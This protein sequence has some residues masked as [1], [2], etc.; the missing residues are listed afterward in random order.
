MFA[1]NVNVKKEK[2]KKEEKEEEAAPAPMEV[3]PSTVPIRP[4]PFQPA[5]IRQPIVGGSKRESSSSSTSGGQQ[6]GKPPKPVTVAFGGPSKGKNTAGIDFLRDEVGDIEKKKEKKKQL[7][8]E[9]ESLPEGY[10]TVLPFI[11]RDK[12]QKKLQGSATE[13]PKRRKEKS[14]AAAL[15]LTSE[16][17]FIDEQLVFFQLPSALP[18][19]FP[20]EKEA[21]TQQQQQQQPPQ[22]QAQSSTDNKPSIICKDSSLAPVPEGVV[23]KLLVYK[24]GKLKLRVGEVLYDV[25]PGTKTGFAQEIAVIDT[26]PSSSISSSSNDDMETNRGNMY[27][28]GDVVK[29][30]I[31]TPDWDYL[32]Q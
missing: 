30:A 10:P 23:G 21:T 1:P 7:Q 17:E 3:A 15:L 25:S 32:L 26:K 11:D 5:N 12:Q 9:L 8:E 31:C 29:T 27:I 24:S 19:G 2:I 13:E 16:G 18:I 22:P 14:A 20:G 4:A 28:L 6:G